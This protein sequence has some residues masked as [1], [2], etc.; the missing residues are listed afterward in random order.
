MAEMLGDERARAWCETALAEVARRQG[1]YDEA[2]ELLHA[3]ARAF[4][5]VGDDGGVAQVRHLMGTLRAQQGEYPQAVANY[6][7]SLRIRERLDDKAGM[8]ALLSNLGVVAE[9]R[10]DLRSVPRVPRAGARPADAARRPARRRGLVDEPRRDRRP[11]ARLRGGANGLRGVDAPQPRGRG[12]LDGRDQRQ[13]PRQRER[14]GSASSRRRSGTTPTACARIA[15]TTTS[16]RSRSSSRTSASWRDSAA[17]RSSRSSSSAPSDTLRDE[18]GTPRAPGLEE[19]LE[20][21]LA[22]AR[23]AIGGVAAT[24]ARAR[25]QALTLTEALDLALGACGAFA[26]T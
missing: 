12:R 24:E 16:G 17:T 19:E 4:E 21:Q 15:S 14:A 10:G 9:Y 5:S 18:I 3:A 22:P 13:Q 8:A 7:A 25:G 6:D 11:R 20:R 2:L 26:S 23:R 1:R